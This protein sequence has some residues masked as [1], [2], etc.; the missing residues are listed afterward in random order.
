MKKVVA[1]DGPAGAGKSTVAKIVADKMGYTYID[2]GAMYRA[3]A[4]KTLQMKKNVT[5]ELILKA[6]ADIDIT[7]RYE[8]GATR[9]FE[10][11]AEITDKI[12]T[13]EI[14]A[15]V[16]Q[17]AKLGAVRDKMTGL[18]RKMAQSDAVIMDGRDIGTVV[19]PRA[20]LK[21][22]LVAS[23]EERAKRRHKELTEKGHDVSF[24]EIKKSIENRDKTDSEREI[25]PLKQADDAILLD[26]TGLTIEEV[27]AKIIELCQG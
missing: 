2:T 4:Y 22:F 3:V 10:G 11:G 7:L 18:Q 26:T 9:V 6:A 13:P 16:S 14:N 21:I 25:A 12:R 5:D 19:L 23:V 20:D 17:V 8:N 27:T 15:I 24:E 1:V